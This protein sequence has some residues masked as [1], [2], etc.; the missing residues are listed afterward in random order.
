MLRKRLMR[1]RTARP[2]GRTSTQHRHAEIALE[3]GSALCIG[4]I[5]SGVTLQNKL[6]LHASS[7]RGLKTEILAYRQEPG[8]KRSLLTPLGLLALNQQLEEKV[9][10]RTL[11][12]EI[13]NAR[14]KELT[15]AKE[16]LMH[17]IVHDMK[18]PLTAMLATLSL[19]E[20]NSFGLDTPIWDL[21][22]GALRNGKKLLDMANDILGISRMRSTE[23][24][25]KRKR[26][27]L[28]ALLQECLTLMSK[29]TSSKKLTFVF[30]PVCPELFLSLDGEIMERV[31]NNLLSNAIKYAPENSRI[32]LEMTRREDAVLVHV[33]NQGSPIPRALHEKIFELFTRIHPTDAQLSGTGIGLN[34]CKLAV[35]A[36]AGNIGVTSPL[37][38]LP[39]GACFTLNLPFR[40]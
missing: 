34:F 14:L 22:L 3:N 20:R 19:F 8:G 12:L 18:N 39:Y 27:D 15:Q 38:G 10:Q 11:E 29:T 13:A 24:A 21:L 28:V 6:N 33:S 7:I 40:T 35:E 9:R 37:P 23:F 36:H 5:T 25:L 26:T 17:M 16:S 30:K 4:E 2:L 31:V 32:T 1:E